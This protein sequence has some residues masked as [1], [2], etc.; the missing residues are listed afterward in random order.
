AAPIACRVEKTDTGAWRV[1]LAAQAKWVTP[2][3]AAVFYQ[4]D[5]VLGGGFIG[6]RPRP[7]AR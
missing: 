5:R 1:L 7:V 6:S 3:Q 4:G 2:G